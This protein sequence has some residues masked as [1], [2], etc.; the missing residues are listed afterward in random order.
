ME[1]IKNV[2][3][4]TLIELLVVIAIIAILA[5]MLLPALAKAREKAQSISCVSNLKQMG[6]AHA[7][8]QDDYAQY[9]PLC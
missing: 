8:Y 2:L 9:I 4:F 5:A 7:M 1:K 3:A 6:L